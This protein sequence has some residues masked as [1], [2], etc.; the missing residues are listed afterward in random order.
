MNTFWTITGWPFFAS[1]APL[2][3]VVPVAAKCDTSV[4]PCKIW[5]GR[6]SNGCTSTE[7]T[8][9]PL[10]RRRFCWLW[11]H[12]WPW[13]RWVWDFV[14]YAC[15]RESARAC[16]ISSEKVGCELELR[17]TENTFLQLELFILWH[18]CTRGY[19]F[20]LLPNAAVFVF[21]LLPPVVWY[22][23]IPDPADGGICFPCYN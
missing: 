13:S 23:R 11:V 4:R 21:T 5:R 8:L 1:P 18:S 9:T 12:R 20:D 17:N 6:S 2:S 19:Y 14:K 16:L 10:R 3:G 22:V 7:T 15:E